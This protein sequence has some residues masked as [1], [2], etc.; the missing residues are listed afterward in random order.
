MNELAEKFANYF[1]EKIVTIRNG[2]QSEAQVSGENEA[3]YS[4]ESVLSS[5]TPATEEEISKFI[6]R[7]ASKSCDLD[8]IPTWLL[9]LCLDSLLPVIT[10]I[11]NLS[12][13]TSDVSPQLKLALIIPLIK[14][15]LL[16]PEVFKNFRPVSNL[17][18]ISKLIER[19]VADRLNTH[20]N[21]NGLH[22]CMQSAYKEHHSTESALLK[23]QNDLLMAIDSD[24]GAI[25]VLLD[26]SAA[27]DTIDHEILF[28]RLFSLGIIG[29]ALQWFKSYLTNRRQSVL[30]NGVRSTTR[31]L[32]FGVPQ[33][34]VLGPILF[35]LYTSPLGDI[36][37]KYGLRFHLYADDT[38]LYI[39]FRPMDSASITVS[40]SVLQ[41][42]IAEIRAWMLRNMLKLN[43]DKTELLVVTSGRFKHQIL[44]ENITVDSAIV[45]PSNNV[46]NLGAQF[47]STLSPESFLN[48]TCKAAWYN[49]RN[50]SRVR[51]SLTMESAKVLIQAYVMSRID[52]CNG[53]LYGATSSQLDRLQ[54]VQNYAARVI[55]RAP[56]YCHITP[57]LSALHWLPIRQRINY[58]IMLF[59]YKARHGLAPQY[60]SDMLHT[61]IPSRALRSADKDLL[62]VP[63][64]RLKGYGGRAFEAAAPS[65]WNVLPEEIKSSESVDVFKKRLKTHLFREAFPSG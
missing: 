57:V 31:D 43:G 64:T 13:T 1:V 59:A 15:A 28:R 65:M 29:N 19:V 37:R 27:F 39:T 33:G 18:Y 23:V 21:Q 11:V 32:P 40:K 5:F 7:S 22:E 12:L 16:D 52:Y 47:N 49:L 36:A 38:Q 2:L 55:M 60:L 25:L 58:K 46:R 17:T 42:C 14:K 6:R 51:N 35:T 30:I 61:Y 53:L 45:T 8:P 48:S 3:D 26:L 24:G 20:L 9:K 4:L 41:N 34:S 44:V 54:K 50:I 63:A 62:V 10:H 56:K